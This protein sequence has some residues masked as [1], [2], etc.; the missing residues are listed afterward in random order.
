MET[1][2]VYDI[3]SSSVAAGLVRFSDGHSPELLWTGREAVVFKKKPNAEKLISEMLRALERVSKNALEQHI[4]IKKIF[5]VF[6]SP[7]THCQTRLINKNFGEVTLITNLFIEKLI[8]DEEKNFD[9]GSDMRVIERRAIHTKLNGYPTHHPFGKKASQAEIPLFIS[10]VGDSILDSVQHTTAKYFNF[11]KSIPHSFMLLSYLTVRDVFA[12]EK[13]FL[14]IDVLGEIST[15]S[16]V[17]GGVLLHSGSFPLGTNSI[18][19]HVAS[20]LN[21]ALD[22]AQSLIDTY[23]DDNIEPSSAKTI[24]KVLEEIKKEWLELF[25]ITVNSLS[26]DVVPPRNLFLVENNKMVFFFAAFLR[27]ERQREAFNVV[28]LDAAKLTDHCILNGKAQKDTPIAL[29]A[30]AINKLLYLKNS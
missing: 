1:S 30:I 28:I 8:H 5:Y 4:Q 19:R 9:L 20:A 27:E 11:R 21:I 2:L 3:G 25:W 26:K 15:V 14:I 29:E 23:F 16:I 10:A 6:S 18:T 12:A 7:W 24:E 22:P 17:I 13:D